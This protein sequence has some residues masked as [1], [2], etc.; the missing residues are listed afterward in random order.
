MKVNEIFKSIQGEGSNIGRICTFIR[1]D[2]CNLK[3][4]WC[5]TKNPPKSTEM[6]VFEIMDNIKTFNCKY[7]TITGGEPLIHADIRTLIVL[8]KI[9]EYTVNIETNGTMMLPKIDGIHY[10]VDIK[11]PSSKMVGHFNDKIL[12]QVSS[13]DREYKF[14]ISNVEDFEWSI[15]FIKD[16]FTNMRLHKIYFNNAWDNVE[17][18]ERLNLL[19]KLVINSG[20][21]IRVGVQLHKVSNVM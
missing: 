9:N 16:N 2:G 3:C 5:D 8:L 21:D 20:Y 1:L 13:I 11:T 7:I 18:R 15:N 17:F 6:D 19:I 4:K 12:N 10:T 14:I